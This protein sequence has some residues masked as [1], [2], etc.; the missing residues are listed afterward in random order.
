M[1]VKKVIKK[2]RLDNFKLKKVHVLGK[3]ANLYLNIFST[4]GIPKAVRGLKYITKISKIINETDDTPLQ[5]TTWNATFLIEK[6]ASSQT[7]DN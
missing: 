6:K 4:F 1:Y 3:S 7:Q 5:L 2:L